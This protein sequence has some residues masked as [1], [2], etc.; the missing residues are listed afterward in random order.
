MMTLSLRALTKQYA[1]G[2]ERCRLD[3]ASAM[4]MVAER[5]T[6]TR[7][8]TRVAVDAAFPFAACDAL[9]FLLGNFDDLRGLKGRVIIE[10]TGDTYL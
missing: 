1:R 8:W 5:E 10:E 6:P 3:I 7:Q 4:Q 2:K 9:A